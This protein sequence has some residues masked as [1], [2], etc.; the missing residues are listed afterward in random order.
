MRVVCFHHAG[1]S[2]SSFLPL[3]RAFGAGVEVWASQLPGHAER[4][5]E[6][7]LTSVDEVA[8]GVLPSVLA[9]ADRPVALFG[10][11]FGAVVAFELARRMAAEG[12]KP[13]HV[14]VS[15]RRAPSRPRIENVHLRSDAEI[16]TELRLLGGPGVELLDDPEVAAAFLPAIR[17]DYQAV[18]TWQPAPG[19]RVDCPLTAMVGDR[20]PRASVD[21][22]RAWRVHTTG[23]FALEIFD[24]GHFYLADHHADIAATVT[25]TLGLG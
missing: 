10:H 15:G 19:L 4:R 11:S 9:Q 2:A 13:R 24:G 8:D 14:F 5:R 16:K 18:E 3:S 17:G 20:D 22:A 23:A 1:G 12:V 25:E 6:P 7:L 21:E